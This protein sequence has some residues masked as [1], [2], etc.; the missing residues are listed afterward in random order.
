MLMRYFI[1]ILLLAG[2]TPPPCTPPVKDAQ[3][4]LVVD[5]IGGL[6]NRLNAIASGAAVA[7]LTGRQLL[8][9]WDPIPNELPAKFQDL[10]VNDLTMLENAPL[11]HGW[12]VMDILDHGVVC[13]S[14]A[15]RWSFS[16]DEYYTLPSM[17]ESDAQ[18]VVVTHAVPFGT[19][20][21]PQESLARTIQAMRNLKPIP[22]LEKAVSDFRNK[23]FGSKR[24]VGVHYRGQA[25]SADFK[26]VA[27][28]KFEIYVEKMHEALKEDPSTVF[29]VASDSQDMV[30]RFEATFPS[31]VFSYPFFEI[32]RGTV[33]DM[34]NAVIDWLLLGHCEYLIGSNTSTFSISAALRTTQCRNIAIGGVDR[35]SNG[36]Q[37]FCFNEQGFIDDGR[38]NSSGSCPAF[39]E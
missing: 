14:V 33:E 12:N 5:T 29:F 1:P 17:L 10:F 21:T 32:S 24:V 2:C 37:L 7:E 36:G 19:A 18:Y 38:L 28:P 6:G 3:R 26:K 11:P 9:W 31:K 25:L 27:R 4:Y 16:N 39:F 13:E 20:S 34:Q 8:V 30:R 22:A 35:N 23:H 15:K